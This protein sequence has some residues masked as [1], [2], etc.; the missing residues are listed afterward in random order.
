MI[1]IE[2]VN[3][4]FKQPPTSAIYIKEKE[5][6]KVNE[7]S[8]FFFIFNWCHAYDTNFLIG[9]TGHVAIISLCGAVRALQPGTLRFNGRFSEQTR[10]TR[11]PDLAI[12][13]FGIMAY[14]RR[15][16]VSPILR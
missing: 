16:A 12:I 9:S 4:S 3:E 6:Q 11:T 7:F 10:C 8:G 15:D 14:A 5:R 2:V 13:L 1:P